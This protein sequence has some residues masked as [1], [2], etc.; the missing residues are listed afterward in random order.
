[1]LSLNFNGDWNVHEQRV[2][3]AE[4]CGA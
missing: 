2:V 1:V 3:H 4:F